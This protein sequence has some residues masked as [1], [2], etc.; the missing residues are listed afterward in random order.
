[1]NEELV[2]REQALLLINQARKNAE[3]AY[4]GERLKGVLSGLS[5]AYSLIERMEAENE[6]AE[7][8][9]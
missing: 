5:I 9:G 2:S 7:E 3:R 1:M 6:E 4:K 8:N